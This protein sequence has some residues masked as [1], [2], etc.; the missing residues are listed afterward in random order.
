MRALYDTCWGFLHK[1][2]E[3]YVQGEYVPLPPFCG[4]SSPSR[5]VD[6]STYEARQHSKRGEFH[7]IKKLG[8]QVTERRG[9]PTR[10]VAVITCADLIYQTR[11]PKRIHYLHLSL[12][13]APIILNHTF[14]DSVRLNH[15]LTLLDPWQ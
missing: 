4:E 11:S 2:R 1:W 14:I 10:S 6:S 9:F 8:P 7:E 15:I 5:D 13:A 12:T 3:K